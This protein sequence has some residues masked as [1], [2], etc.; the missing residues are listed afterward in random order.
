MCISLP[1]ENSFAHYVKQVDYL[2]GQN[3]AGYILNTML[4]RHKAIDVLQNGQYIDVIN[5]IDKFQD[6]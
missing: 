2:S 4:L 1:V 6:K 3:T 5:V